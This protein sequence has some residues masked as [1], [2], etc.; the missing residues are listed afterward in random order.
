MIMTESQ[1]RG[2]RRARDV[3]KKIM[4]IVMDVL[5]LS[6]LGLYLKR[7]DTV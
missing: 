1:A 4:K 7:K 5:Y 2:S 3:F 6:N